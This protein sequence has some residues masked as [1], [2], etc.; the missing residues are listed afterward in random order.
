MNQLGLFK[1]WLQDHLDDLKEQAPE[2][3]HEINDLYQQVTTAYET[4]LNA[5]LV[6][7]DDVLA[8]TAQLTTVQEEIQRRIDQNDDIAGIIDKVATGVGIATKIAG[9]FIKP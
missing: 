4:A 1:D 9:F 6:G 3:K 2:R 5:M 7:N 8:L